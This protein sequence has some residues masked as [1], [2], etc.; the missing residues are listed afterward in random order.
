MPK[1][2]LKSIYEKHG[3]TRDKFNAIRAKGVNV[4]NE[5]ELMEAIG[6][7]RHRLP[8]D[9]KLHGNSKAGKAQNLEEVE[10]ALMLSNDNNQIKLLK[11]KLS[12]LKI[13]QAIR[14]ESRD[15]IPVGE[16]REAAT[17]VISAARGE[18]LKLTSD[19]PPRLAGLSESKMQTVIRSEIIETLTRLS[20]EAGALYAD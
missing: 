3:L 8:D 17:K 11:D 14:K 18:L 7:Q 5:A 1:P 10:A 2:T 15:L 16:V 13:A 19:L 6:S 12:G 4:Y 9:A 20:N